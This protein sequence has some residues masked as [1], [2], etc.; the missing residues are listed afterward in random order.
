MAGRTAGRHWGCRPVSET[1]TEKLNALEDDEPTESEGVMDRGDIFRAAYTLVTS[2]T[3]A[4]TPS[5]LDVIRV[6][7]FMGDR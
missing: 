2:L 1:E 5:V 6:A 3:W 7:E 4:E